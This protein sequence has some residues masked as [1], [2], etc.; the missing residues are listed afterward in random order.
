MSNFLGVWVPLEE[1]G[2]DKMMSDGNWRIV[3]GFPILLALFSIAV[4][5]LWIKEFSVLS[6]LKRD[7]DKPRAIAAICRVYLCDDPEA[8]YASLKQENSTEEPEVSLFDSLT[9][10]KYRYA[11]WN[12]LALSVYHQFSGVSAILLFSTKIF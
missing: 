6:L 8:K 10:K 1:E 5:V 2:A 9:N 11:S 7:E 12:S 4:I 3:Y